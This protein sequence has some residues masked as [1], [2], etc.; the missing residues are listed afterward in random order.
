MAAHEGPGGGTSPTPGCLVCG[1]T[2]D[3]V[4]LVPFRYREAERSICA[5]HLPILIHDPARL[6]DVLPGAEDMDPAEHED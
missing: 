4:P 6:A 2:S 3:E 5:Q 1:R